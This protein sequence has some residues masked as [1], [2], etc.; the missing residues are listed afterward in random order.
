MLTKNVTL[1]FVTRGAVLTE[2]EVKLLLFNVCITVCASYVPVLHR[3][4]GVGSRGYIACNVVSVK[5]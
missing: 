3:F 2:R 5:L 4:A 1:I